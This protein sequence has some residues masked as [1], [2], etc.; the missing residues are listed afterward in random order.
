MLQYIIV[1][2]IL[3]ASIAYAT[4]RVYRSLKQADQGCYNAC[5]GCELAQNCMKQNEKQ[6]HG[7]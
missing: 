5:Q 2:L 6:T 3:A 4:V 1:F 7:E